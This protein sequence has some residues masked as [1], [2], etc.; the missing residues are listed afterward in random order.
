VSERVP[1]YDAWYEEHAAEYA[2]QLDLVRALLMPVGLGLEVGV[3]TAQFAGPLGVAVGA[4]PSPDMC[5]RSRERGVAAVRAV[6]ERLPFGDGV[7]DSAL[8]VNVLFL[9]GDRRAVLGE[10]RRV[11]KPAGVLVVAETDAA[12]PL[13]RFRSER[14]REELEAHGNSFLTAEGLTALLREGGFFPVAVAQTLFGSPEDPASVPGWEE[15][16]GRGGFVVVKALA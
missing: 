9:V 6:G 7:F 12:T 5:R 4:D 1:E 10:L 16:H 8:M 11:L 2:Q 13:G 3:G 15:G 14:Y